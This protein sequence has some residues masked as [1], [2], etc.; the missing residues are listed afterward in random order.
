MCGAKALS[1]A[2]FPHVRHAIIGE[3]TNLRPVRMHKGIFMEGIHLS[4]LAGHSSDPNLGRS[5]LE[6]MHAVISD[7]LNW[8]REL[9]EKY[10]NPAFAVPVPTLNLGDIHGGDNPN[11]ICGE[12]ELH[13]DLRPLP[14]MNLTELKQ[15]LHERVR[16]VIEPLELKAEFI[17]LFEGIPAVETA[18]EAEIVRVAKRLTQQ[19]SEAVAFATEAPYLNDLG[20]ET[21]VLDPAI[22]HKPINPMSF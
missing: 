1:R 19:T 15:I 5:A 20:I 17:S 12:C 13:I 9:Q 16:R 2:S 22:L 6:G 10:S 11:R 8:R 4:G 14:S 3:P 7:L 18:T 21:I